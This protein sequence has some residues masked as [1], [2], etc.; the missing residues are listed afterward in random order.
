MTD[1]D[2]RVLVFS[3]LNGIAP[4]VDV[5]ALDPDSSLRAT[6]DLDS[7][8]FLSYVAALSEVIDAD[9]PES[10]YGRIDT[11]NGAATYLV[12]RLG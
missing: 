10:D 9:I 2:A 7:M 6:A 12:T 1:D 11:L 5:A 4:E 3:A 8:D